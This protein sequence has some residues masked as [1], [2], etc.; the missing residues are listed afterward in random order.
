MVSTF[1]SRAK[2][3]WRLAAGILLLR[4]KEQK[5]H[6]VLVSPSVIQPYSWGF[7]AKSPSRNKDGACTK[8]LNT[9]DYRVLK[10]KELQL[11]QRLDLPLK[12]R[13]RNDLKTGMP[14]NKT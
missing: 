11:Q 10:G 3:S 14:Q 12:P 8:K 7:R 6:A 5:H 13:V 9:V 4:L 2:E 1:G